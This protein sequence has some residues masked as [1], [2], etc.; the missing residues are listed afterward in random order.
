LAADDGGIAINTDTKVRCYIVQKLHMSRAS[1][2]QRVCFA[3]YRHTGYIDFQV[4]S[5]QFIEGIRVTVLV[6]LI[7]H[8]FQSL[9]LL[10]IRV[11][12]GLRKALSRRE[13]SKRKG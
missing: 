2:V 12:S 9:K 4:V 10:N 7:P 6:C 3:H 11:A 8:L 13:H 5:P 1:K